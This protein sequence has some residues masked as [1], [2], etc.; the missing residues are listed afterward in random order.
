[1]DFPQ[2][3][4]GKG[5]EGL[6]RIRP[7]KIWV[8]E[9]PDL[10]GS[11]RGERILQEEVEEEKEGRVETEAETEAETERLWSLSSREKNKEEGPVALPNWR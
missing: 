5:V 8:V 10:L 1:M 3:R 2:Y 9:L 11:S 4:L 7:L 6:Q